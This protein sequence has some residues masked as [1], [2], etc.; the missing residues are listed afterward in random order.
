[1]SA[2]QARFAEFVLGAVGFI[3]TVAVLASE[4]SNWLAAFGAGLMAAAAAVEGA[5]R[6]DPP[7]K[8]T[9]PPTR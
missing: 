2:V 6:A 5:L 9:E 3:T 4:A 8:P 7:T 1:M